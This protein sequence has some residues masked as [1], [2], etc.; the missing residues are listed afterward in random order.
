MA[1]LKT[2][3]RELSVIIG[4]VF[5][6]LSIIKY[7]L[8]P[9][10]FIELILKYCSNSIDFPSEIDKIN[11]ES[12]TSAENAIIRNGIELGKLIYENI[13]ID[14]KILWLGPINRNEYP[15]DIFIGNIQISLKEESFILKN[16]SFAEYLN[17]LVSPK[18]PFKTIHIFR[19][20][21]TTEFDKWF[22]Y[23]FT[24]L[25]A[26]SAGKDNIIYSYTKNQNKYN[27]KKTN[28][29]IS[30]ED[31]SRSY[32]LI[33]DKTITEEYFNQMIPGDIIEHTFSKWVKDKLEKNDKEYIKL[34]K[35]CSETA[36]RNL[37]NFIEENKNINSYR[38]LE[39]LQIFDN[40]YYY[41]KNDGK[42]ISLYKVPKKSDCVLSIKEMHFTVP[43]SQLN[44][45][46]TFEISIKI[47]SDVKSEEIIM[48]VEC[49]YSH[50]QFKGIPE[51]KLYCKDDLSKLYLL[52]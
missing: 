37:I 22:V 2:I 8:T 16:P 12:F 11:K 13:A 46:F 33:D 14:G 35:I 41:A 21:A 49:R 9:T 24:K 40:D 4:Y 18:E 7:E 5:A 17:A 32:L 19:K 38:F 28:S 45:F 26:T 50:G 1:D 20:F 39:I 27:I 30:F 6:Q 48:H 29:G 10:E 43:K 23:T 36:G 47:K 44:V 3:L 42:K 15:S 34:K 51:A 52:M 31:N 25:K